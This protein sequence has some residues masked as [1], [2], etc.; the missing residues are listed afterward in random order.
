MTASVARLWKDDHGQD[1]AEYAV[2]LAVILVIVVDRATGRFE[3]Q[4]HFFLG[5]EFDSVADCE[6]QYSNADQA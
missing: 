1:I 3:R 5:V 4:Q 2:L 6:A